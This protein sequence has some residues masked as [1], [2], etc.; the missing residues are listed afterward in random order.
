MI[1]NPLFGVVYL[2]ISDFSKPAKLA[3][4]IFHITIQFLLTAQWVGNYFVCK[5]FAVQTL[6]WSLEFVI[7]HDTMAMQFLSRNF[8]LQTSPHSTL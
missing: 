6:L 1:Q 5:R 2:L 8:I 3:T 4:K 7:Q